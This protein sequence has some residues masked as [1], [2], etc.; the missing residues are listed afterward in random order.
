MAMLHT[1]L[2]LVLLGVQGQQFRVVGQVELNANHQGGRASLESP[3]GKVVIRVY[4]DRDGEFEFR[5]LTPGSY[6]VVFSL[7]GFQD[8][9]RSIEVRPSLADSNRRIHIKIKVPGKPRDPSQQTISVGQLQIPR[10]AIR[11][12]HRA[13]DA[14]GDIKKVR[15]H[16]EQAIEIAP[17]FE[18]A[19]NN[20][21]TIYHRERNYI[22][23][24]E[25][26][27][28]A[29]EVNPESFPAQVNLGGSVFARIGRNLGSVTI[30]ENLQLERAL[31]A[32]TKALELRPD[33]SLANS[34]TGITLF[35]LRRYQEAIPYFE[36]VKELD[37]FSMNT[38]ELFL[39]DIY[40]RN[41]DSD[42]A[43]KELESFLEKLPDHPRAPRVRRRLRGLQP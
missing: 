42:R 31:R 43:V 9:R 15:K 3:D 18:E 21:G 17:N 6:W 12:Y 24:I 11:E 35:F 2:L 16:L 1:F 5:N 19:L 13:R 8:F 25:L 23:A 38:P 29:L 7:T 36:K 14:G 26:F 40:L 37:P 27:E 20:L 32:N 28:R 4:V 22:R 34:Q 30:E 39:S 10:E 41:G 33:S